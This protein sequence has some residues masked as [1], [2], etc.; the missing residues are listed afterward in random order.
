MMI[1]ITHTPNMT[2]VLLAEDSED[3]EARY[4]ALHII[5]GPEETAF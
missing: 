4:D 5:V 1:D 3:F 2:G